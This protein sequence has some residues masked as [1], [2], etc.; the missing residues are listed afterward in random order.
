MSVCETGAMPPEPFRYRPTF[1]L[2]LTGVV[3]ALCVVGAAS[4]VAVGDWAGLARATSPLSFAA[5]LV[6]ALFWRPCIVITESCVTVVN[7]FRTYDVPWHAIERIDTRYAVTLFTATGRIAVWAAPSPGL[8]GATTIGK[9]DVSNLTESS[10]GPEGTVR[11][12]DAV[13]TP[14]G[15]VAFVLRRRWEEIRDQGADEQGSAGR[16][17][18]GQAS[19]PHER[20]AGHVRVVTHRA[21]VVALVVLAVTS[22]VSAAV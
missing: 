5:I 3:V 10:Y 17:P 4:L 16:A 22:L 9:R 21:T 1:G 15:Q 20:D 8:R 6:I 18:A 7:V 19:G 2:V 13:S 14:S 12:G 11:P